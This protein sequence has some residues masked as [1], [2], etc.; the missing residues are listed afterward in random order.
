MLVLLLAIVYRLLKN[1]G[2]KHKRART[3]VRICDPGVLFFS[4]TSNNGNVLLQTQNTAFI[5][6]VE[7]RKRD[8]YETFQR[9][10]GDVH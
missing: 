3:E 9:K 2:S 1:G 8:K 6:S 4:H 5:P 7:F 10:L